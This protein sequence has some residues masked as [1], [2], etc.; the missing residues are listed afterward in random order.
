MPVPSAIALGGRERREH[1]CRSTLPRTSRTST[2]RPLARQAAAAETAAVPSPANAPS[3]RANPSSEV[4]DLVCRL[5]LPTLIYRQEAVHLGDLL[6]I[7]V[8]S[9][10]TPPR[11]PR[12]DFQGPD[13]SSPDAA[14][15]WRRSSLSQNP[16]SLGEDSRASAAYG[17][18]ITLPEAHAGVSVSCRVTAT[19]RPRTLPHATWGSQ[20]KGLSV[21]LPGTGILAGLPFAQRVTTSRLPTASIYISAIE[22]SKASTECC[23][24]SIA[25]SET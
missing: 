11:S 15:C 12:T 23:L 20:P 5:P 3:L 16:I 9:G 22:A 18:K 10:A 1:S 6:R 2:R 13:V 8:R 25:S 7:W 14:T 24:I 21:P 4:T 19:N 17:E